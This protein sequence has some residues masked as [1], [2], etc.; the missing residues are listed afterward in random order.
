M[1]T[2]I[3]TNIY[4][5]NSLDDFLKLPIGSQLYAGRDF[6]HWTSYEVHR[7]KFLTNL[8]DCSSTVPIAIGT[9]LGSRKNGT[10]IA[11]RSES[12]LL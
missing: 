6:Y 2:N 7:H 3:R 12:Y 10:G 4:N 5:C 8:Q 11:D 9:S 1:S